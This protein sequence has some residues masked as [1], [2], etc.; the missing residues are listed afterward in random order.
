[1]DRL[2]QLNEPPVVVFEEAYDI[3]GSAVSETDPNHLGRCAVHQAHLV[4][5]SV[6][7]NQCEP[8]LFCVFPDCKGIST[9]KPDRSKVLGSGEWMLELVDQAWRQVL[10]EEQL[11]SGGI[12]T[13]L[14]SRSAANCRQARMSAASRSGKS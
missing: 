2:G 5:V 13:N 10:I 7:R 4:E 6:L 14:R 9:R 8:M 3:T 11:H 12:E 1:M